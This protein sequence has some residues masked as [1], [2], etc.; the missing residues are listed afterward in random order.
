MRSLI[1]FI[2]ALI[3]ASSCTVAHADP[4][5]DSFVNIY[6]TTCLKY[7]NDLKSLRAILERTP[8]LPPEKASQFLEGKPGSAWPVP[9]KHGLFVLAILDQTNMCIVY[10]RRADPESVETQVK[11]LVASAPP[12]LLARQLSNSR[13]QTAKSGVTHTLSYEWSATGA[14]RKLLFMLTTA[15]SE[16][17]ELQAVATASIMQ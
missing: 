16:S 1:S 8:K 14:S 5:A 9:D 13:S 12:P 2:F 4:A 10:A 11:K 6:A 17:A 3:T 15:S 7:I